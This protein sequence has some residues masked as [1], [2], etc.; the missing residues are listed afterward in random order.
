V[1]DRALPTVTA[2]SRADPA[3][4]GHATPAT[5]GPVQ[6]RG[7]VFST[8]RVGAFVHLTLVA[9]G[10]AERTR[11]GN[12]VAVAVGGEMSGMLLRRAF[13]IYRARPSAVYGGTVEIVVSPT[14]PG[15]RWLV[16]RRPREPVSV[17]GPI[18][19]PFSLPGEPVACA[20]VGE[21]TGAVPMFLLADRLRQRGCGVHML[22]G[23]DTERGLFGALEAKRAAQS[24]TVATGDGSAG[25]RGRVTDLLPQLI[26]RRAVEVVYACGPP[27]TLA[28]L[29][30]IASAYAVWSQTAVLLSMPCGVG[31]CLACVLPVR[32]DDG[33]VRM[34]RAC[35]DGPAFQ[36]DRVQWPA[37]AE[38]SCGAPASASEDGR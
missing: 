26:S 5:S 28:S 6:V 14:E 20:L 16:E 15:T 9:D 13:P 23:A 30:S 33:V 36:G 34:S 29:S 1:N 38:P 19:R 27:P 17:L 24:V 8:K 25:I 32:G 22:L 21:A 3:G 37:L 31:V 4:Q 18:G 10:I 11:P 2:A 12:L 7:E 35:V